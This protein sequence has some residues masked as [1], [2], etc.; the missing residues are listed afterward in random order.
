MV[1]SERLGKIQ[2]VLGPIDPDLL[3]ITLTHEHLLIDMECYFE[4]PDEASERAWVDAP[5]TMDRLGGLSSRLHNLDNIK[6]LDER[7]A[8]E[9][10]SHYRHEGGN[11]IVDTTSIGIARDPLALARISRATGVN[12]VMGASHYVPISY[13]PDMDSLSEEEIADRIIADVTAGVGETQI[14]SGIIGEVGCHWP[15]TDNLRKVLRASAHAQQ[16]TGAPISIHPGIH[17]DSPTQILEILVES[18]ARADRVIIGHLDLFNDNGMLDDL[19]GAGCLMEFDLF[20]V[21]DTSASEMAGQEIVVLSDV[22]RLEKI[23][24]LVEQGH[25]SKIVIAHDVCTKQQYRR[26]GGKSYAH[27]LANLV[28]RMRSRGFSKDQIDSILVDNPKRILTFV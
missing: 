7:S 2:T 5:V 25:L 24:R 19:A 15:M 22:Q 12:V 18:G 23:E 6:L 20:G 21:E 28:P 14:K 10:V 3:G 4:M 1:G 27:I 26:Y 16:E 13:P 11:S 17:H 9:E 8:I